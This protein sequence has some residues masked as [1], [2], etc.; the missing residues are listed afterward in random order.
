MSD[1]LT[2][3]LR[4][5]SWATRELM[6]FCRR[7]APEQLRERAEGTYGSVLATFQHLIWAEGRYR[8][9]LTGAKPDWSREAEE[10]ED[11]D[12]LAT[13]ADDNAGF[14]EALA[15]DGFDPDRVCTW[16]STVS[17]AHTEAAA[18][19]LVAQAIHHGSE[20]RAQIYTV[21]TAIGVEP[22]HYDCWEYGLATGRFRETPPR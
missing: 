12:D 10:V 3:P 4:H 20:H 6:A 17:G 11:L 19:L 8:W 5:N 13:M 2:D 9:R 18:G 14:W 7:L 15:A 1:P 21:L 22:S 16:I